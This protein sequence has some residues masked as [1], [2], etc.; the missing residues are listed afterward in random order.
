MPWPLTTLELVHL[1]AAV[2]TLWSDLNTS[3]LAGSHGLVQLYSV[4]YH[5]GRGASRQVHGA[6]QSTSCYLG[7]RRTTMGLS[8]DHIDLTASTPVQSMLGPVGARVPLRAARL[9]CGV[10]QGLQSDAAERESVAPVRSCRALARQRGM[11]RFAPS[12]STPPSRGP[13]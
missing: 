5:Q 8:S 11:W 13:S 6:F 7:V 4:P 1:G 9:R 12:A 2:I 10:R 3:L